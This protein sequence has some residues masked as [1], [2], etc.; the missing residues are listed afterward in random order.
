MA[1]AL[2]LA[3]GQ[4]DGGTQARETLDLAVISDYTM[5]MRRGDT[6][7]PIDVYFDGTDYWLADGFH[8]V[9]AAAGIGQDMIAAI[10]HQGGRRAALL[11]AAGANLAH[12]L[13]R[14]NA[15]KH[16]AVMT[17]LADEEWRKWSDRQIARHCGVDHKFVAK[18]RGELSGDI[19]RSSTRKVQR[20][21]STYTMGTG[22][23]GTTQAARPAKVITL[24]TGRTR[25]TPEARAGTQPAAVPSAS[26]VVPQPEVI[27]PPVSPPVESP[28]VVAPEPVQQEEPV[29]MPPAPALVRA[30]EQASGEER[31]EF[32]TQHRT[33]LLELLAVQE[34]QE[35]PV[36]TLPPDVHPDTQPGLILIVLRTATA[37][38][39]Q[40]ELAQTPGINRR[41]LGRDLTRMCNAGHIAKTADGRYVLG[42]VSQ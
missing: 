24:P 32:V 34:K 38:L 7:P 27:A 2:S 10:V 9:A 21:K 31:Q 13:R 26:A 3:L 17:L 30:W 4:T 1:E 6:F 8:R 28:A 14:T 12:G 15:D 23:I 19:P 22:R 5:A 36:Q 16:K 41:V 18:T 29:A 42:V 25:E 39:S 33:V 37:P 20:G 35:E 11:H 40:E